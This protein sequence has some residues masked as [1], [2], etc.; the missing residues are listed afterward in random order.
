VNSI[1]TLPWI[2]HDQFPHN[3]Y[4][5]IPPCTHKFLPVRDKYSLLLIRYSISSIRSILTSLHDLI[6][7]HCKQTHLLLNINHHFQGVFTTSKS[8]HTNC[9]FTRSWEKSSKSQNLDLK[10]YKKI[11]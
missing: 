3:D 2:F 11:N 4:C 8:K 1:N 7:E 10:E 6:G 5:P 9:K